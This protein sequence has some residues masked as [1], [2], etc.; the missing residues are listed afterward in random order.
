MRH[1][2]AYLSVHVAFQMN[3]Y[4]LQDEA[5]LSWFAHQT[6]SI[7]IKGQYTYLG[8]FGEPPPLC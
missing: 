5:F 1:K 7:G 2:P 3:G 8:T 4:Q 6:P